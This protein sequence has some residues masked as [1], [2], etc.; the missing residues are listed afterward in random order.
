MTPVLLF[1]DFD[2]V[3]RPHQAPAGRFCPHCLER[4]ENLLREFERL[5]VVI[6]SDWRIL[7][8]LDMLRRMFSDD[9]QS[10]IVGA[11]PW[12]GH[13]D[14]GCRYDEIIAYLEER[15]P[16]PQT[17]PPWLAIDDTPSLYP[18]SVHDDPVLL[19]DPVRALDAA[20]SQRVRRYLL[21]LLDLP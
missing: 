19:T 4:F 15:F 16:A 20:M 7:R 12:L 1:L 10:R 11:T 6:A 13:F 18:A 5:E 8:P 21:Q 2:G 14:D 9:V 3:L 17:K